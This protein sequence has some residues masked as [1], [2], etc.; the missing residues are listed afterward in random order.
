M[1]TNNSIVKISVASMGDVRLKTSKRADGKTSVFK[2]LKA[3]SKDVVLLERTDKPLHRRA[4]LVPN[5]AN[6]TGIVQLVEKDTGRAMKGTYSV[7]S[8][9]P[10]TAEGLKQLAADNKRSSLAFATLRTEKSSTKSTTTDAASE[11]PAAE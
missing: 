9:A 2:S 1:N 11:T 7:L 10:F 5:G 4:V 8:S 3:G 6:L